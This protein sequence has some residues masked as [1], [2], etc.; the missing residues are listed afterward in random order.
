MLKFNLDLLKIYLVMLKLA[1]FAEGRR[2]F[3]NVRGDYA[4][5]LV[6]FAKVDGAFAEVRLLF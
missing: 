2:T 4:N 6:W 1:W 5:E 3:A